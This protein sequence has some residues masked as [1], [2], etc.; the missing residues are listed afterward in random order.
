MKK[1]RLLLYCLLSSTLHRM[2]CFVDCAFQGKNHEFMQPKAL[3]SSSSNP[4]GLNSAWSV[5]HFNKHLL[6]NTRNI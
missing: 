1:K 5:L 4:K 2:Q 6:N 3:Y